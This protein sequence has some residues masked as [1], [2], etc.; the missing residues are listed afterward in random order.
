[1]K[2]KIIMVLLIVAVLFLIG[3]GVTY[4]IHMDKENN[5]VYGIITVDVNP[6]MKIS[7]NRKN[8]VL[9]VEALNNDA[10]IIKTDDL[11]GKEIGKALDVVVE[12][13]QDNGYLKEKNNTILINVESDNKELKS[14]VK[15]EI[16]KITEDKKIESEV[17]VQ[18]IKVNEEIKKVSE[19]NNIS[20]SKAAYLIE[21]IKD[22][23]EIDIKDVVDKNLEEVR[24]VVENKK[25]EIRK[26]EEEKIKEAEKKENERKS[27]Q[28]TT[29]KASVPKSTTK[30]ATQAK[31][32]SGGY[33]SVRECERAKENFTKQNMYEVIKPKVPSDISQFVGFTYE[34][35]GVLYSGRCGY[36]MD[37]VYDGAEHAFIYDITNGEEIAHLVK[38][39]NACNYDQ[40]MSLAKDYLVEGTSVMTVGSGG[41]GASTSD[42]T[43]S[44]NGVTH[45]IV[46]NRYSGAIISSN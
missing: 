20:E 4:K 5:T 21:Q 29:T 23:E 34:A 28:L 10:Q 30:K 24:T 16:E 14:I 33:G 38:K 22:V 37:F 6:S 19:E 41:Y 13:L 42:I 12:K 1:M 31:S 26:A 15:N 8:Q 44:L 3:M 39:C 32:N 35:Y 40:I 11:K 2:K 17:I 36:R 43:Y 46:F 7:L 18:E 45:T 25:E 9:K 27:Q